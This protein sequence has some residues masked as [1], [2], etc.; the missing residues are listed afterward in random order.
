MLYRGAIEAIAAARCHLQ[1]GE[2]RHRSHQIMRAFR[3]L[4]ELS[5]SLDPQY[6]EIS[7][8]LADLYGYMQRQ[9][10]DANGEQTDAPLAEVE[11]LLS[12]LLEGWKA[13]VVAPV[14][15][16]PEEYEPVSCTY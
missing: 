1:A 13:A 2:I 4:Q 8:P 12:T 3:I 15:V 5:R 11:R 7:R 16:S 14:R 10:L 6:P 9:L